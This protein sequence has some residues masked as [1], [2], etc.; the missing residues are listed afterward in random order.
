MENQS[1][2]QPRESGEQIQAQ[3]TRPPATA[4][5]L[6]AFA[7]ATHQTRQKR[8]A[9]DALA[10]EIEAPARR[11]QAPQST[12]V[13]NQ[14]FL[15]ASSIAPQEQG[16]A[17]IPTDT[18][19]HSEKNEVISQAP[20]DHD[21]SQLVSPALSTSPHQESSVITATQDQAHAD[22]R[23]QLREGIRKEMEIVWESRLAKRTS[24][25]EN[26]WRAKREERTK[27]VEGY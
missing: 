16:Q 2:E 20:D 13:H 19:A 11:T 21:R 24:E 6:A 15:Q 5:Q 10:P 23:E 27:V 17:I 7:T 4:Q 1:R 9:P 25:V 14:R 26:V 18:T 8:E 12:R 3:P 22:L